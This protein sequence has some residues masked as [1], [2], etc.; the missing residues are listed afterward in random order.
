MLGNRIKELREEKGLK[1]DELAKIIS[2]SPSAIGMYERNER[3]PN[4]DIS[5]KLA[6][7]FDVSLDYMLGKSDIK[8]SLK[9]NIDEADIAFASGVKALNE[10]N[11][12]IIKNTLE[13]LLA[14]QEKDTKED[15]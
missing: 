4:D 15:K 3:E 9:V 10:T 13:A 6:N 8:T 2:I 5:I 1:Q 14:K 12:M 11:K 7:F